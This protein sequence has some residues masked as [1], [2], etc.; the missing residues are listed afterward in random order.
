MNAKSAGLCRFPL[1]T[2]KRY[3]APHLQAFSTMA[4]VYCQLNVD[5]GRL[6]PLFQAFIA[7]CQMV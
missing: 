7:L 1:H 2:R 6:I 3:A 5:P 4:Q